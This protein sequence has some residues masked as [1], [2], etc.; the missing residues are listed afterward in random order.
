MNILLFIV[1]IVFGVIFLIVGKWKFP[2]KRHN[3]NDI[4]II[5]TPYTEQDHIRNLKAMLKEE[6]PCSED[7]CPLQQEARYVGKYNILHKDKE[8]AIC[9]KCMYF[10]KVDLNKCPCDQLGSEKAI[11]LTY[12]VLNELGV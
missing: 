10:L 12:K 7:V 1:L 11:S 6:T 4:N 3:P 9:W 5:E 8:K 2:I